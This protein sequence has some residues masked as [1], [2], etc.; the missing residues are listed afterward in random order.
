MLSVFYIV[1]TKNL[2]FGLIGFF[3]CGLIFD[4]YILLKKKS[5]S[6]RSLNI[7]CLSIM[8]ME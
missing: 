3:N 5:S 7:S 2:G 6:M 1:Y 8:Q 4:L